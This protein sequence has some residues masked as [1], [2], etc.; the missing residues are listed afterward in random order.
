MNILCI[1]ESKYN[2]DLL[3]EENKTYNTK[4]E[5]I[6][7]MSLISSY[8]LGSWGENVYFH[9]LVGKDIYGSKIVKELK[10]VNV[11]IK[12]IEYSKIEDTSLT[13]GI[14][15]NNKEETINKKIESELK[16]KEY[17]FIPEIIFS[18]GTSPKM[19]YKVFNKFK[20]AIKLLYVNSNNP[21]VLKVC[22]LSTYLIFPIEIAEDISGIKFD[23]NNKNTLEEIYQKLKNLYSKIIIIDLESSGTVFETSDKIKLMGKIKSDRG[24]KKKNKDIFYGALLYGINKGL[25]LE[26]SIKIATIAEYLSLKKTDKSI[27][28]PEL[29]EVYEIYK[30]N[31]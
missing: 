17:K 10:S 30:K 14:I 27:F 31:Q 26:K 22:K 15:K 8:L 20:D 25:E 13:L 9:G 16:Y 23:P 7:G 29:G 5:Y 11:K 1:G 4:A 19:I 6:L 12:Y 28:I 3:V 2:I 24:Y 18:D 21:E